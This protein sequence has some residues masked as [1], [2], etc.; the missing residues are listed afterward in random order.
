MKRVIEWMMVMRL[1]ISFIRHS[2]VFC[3]VFMHGDLSRVGTCA[4]LFVCRRSP[5]RTEL[6]SLSSLVRQKAN[7][8]TQRIYRAGPPI[9]I[10]YWAKNWAIGNFFAIVRCREVS[11]CFR[12][13]DS[14]V[15]VSVPRCNVEKLPQTKSSEGLF[16]V[17]TFRQGRC[18]NQFRLLRLSKIHHCC[19]PNQI[20]LRDPHS[21]N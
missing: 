1:G 20:C 2:S 18:C 4:L 16:S 12:Q 6:A 15:E 19:K 17:T 11:D 8:V 21:N 7:P 5:N 14:L 3:L 13:Y 10:G 9:I